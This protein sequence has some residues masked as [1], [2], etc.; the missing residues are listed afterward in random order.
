MRENLDM[1]YAEPR[2]FKI[3]SHARSHGISKA[4]IMGALANVELVDEET[5]PGKIVFFGPTSKASGYVLSDAGPR[6]MPT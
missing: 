3:A 5:E 2:R 4:R 6:R 1:P